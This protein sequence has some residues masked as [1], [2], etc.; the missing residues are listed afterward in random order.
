LEAPCTSREP[1]EKW[2]KGRLSAGCQGGGLSTLS[3]RLTQ[4]A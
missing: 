1:F 2:L 4:H 3:A